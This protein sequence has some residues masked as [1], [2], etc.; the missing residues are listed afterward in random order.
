M[1]DC[2]CTAP[3][4]VEGQ[5]LGHDVGRPAANSTWDLDKELASLC[6]FL[7]TLLCHVPDCKIV[8]VATKVPDCVTSAE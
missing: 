6:E 8:T 5:G 1:F 3:K 4:V 7:K 2:S